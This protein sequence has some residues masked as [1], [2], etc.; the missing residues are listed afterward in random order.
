[1][2]VMNKMRESTGAILWILVLAFG[3]LWVLQDSGVFDVITGGR[4][5]R[6]IGRVDGEP[7]DSE[8]FSN[9]V[10]QQ[11]Q[12]YQQ[13]GIEVSNAMRLQ[14]QNAV[15][16]GLVDN[17]LLEREMDRLGIAVTDEEVYDLITG[18]RPD[19]TIAQ[20][21]PDGV[22]GVDRAAL[23]QVAQDPQYAPQLSAIEEQVRRNRRQAKL[24]ALLGASVVVSDQAVAAEFVRQQR[25]ASGRFVA[26]RYADVPDDQVTV[27]DADLRRYYRENQSTFERKRTYQVEYVAFEKAPTAADSARALGELS[28]LAPGLAQAADP[29]AFARSQAFGAEAEATFT[30][31]ADLAPELATAVYSDLRVGRVVGPVVAGGQAVVARITGVRPAAQP[32]VRARHILLPVN[33]AEAARTLRGRI[34]RGEI[35]F[36]EA[37]RQSSIDESNKM[38]GGELGWFGRGRMVAE[39]ERA[40]FDAPVGQVVGP[41]QTQFGQHLVLVESRATQEPELVQI[42]RP[43]EADFSEVQNRAEDW[44]V[45][46]LEGERRDFSEAAQEAGLVTTQLTI[47]EDQPY[48]PSLQVGR[49]LFRFLRRARVGSVSEPFDAGDRFVIVRVAEILPEGVTPFDD[50]RDQVEAAVLT[51]KKREVQSRRL[52]EAL[53]T[54]GGDL[55]R[56]APAVGSAV[57]TVEAATLANPTLIGFGREP[58][59]VGALFGLQPGQRSGVVEGDAAVFVV[60]TTGLRGA[61]DAELTA[62]R[63]TELRNQIAAQRR[64][65]LVQQWL[66]GLRDQAE[67]EDFRNDLL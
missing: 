11:L 31:A 20:Y 15:F 30:S 7:I 6:I 18:P 64:Q 23:Q 10:E 49:E 58:R 54:A 44:V 24:G 2:G 21:F 26:L 39:F 59:A 27:T 3:G 46:N 65:Q 42:T 13:Q 57:Q 9:A 22:G 62:E 8:L 19:P 33:A 37:A 61:T 17:A 40:A 52:T 43:V 56:L 45:I 29:S 1:M 50:V 55:A 5:G 34:E 12:G 38:Q 47:E 66:R 67:V 53:A 25:Q 14:A 36:A 60:E 51:E 48:V 63:R 16:E 28:R 32:V 35:T 41:V 4:S